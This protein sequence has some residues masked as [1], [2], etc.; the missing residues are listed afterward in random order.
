[1]PA[2]PRRYN[3]RYTA[4]RERFFEDIRRDR[5]QF[6]EDEGDVEQSALRIV[7]DVGDFT[8]SERKK[9]QNTGKFRGIRTFLDLRRLRRF[10]DARK[11]NGSGISWGRRDLQ[12]YDISARLCLYR[13]VG[14]RVTGERVIHKYIITNAER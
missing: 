5:L 9:A 1:M 3:F 7:F 13:M 11:D 14:N 8:S 10:L 12:K 4:E 2:R 6:L